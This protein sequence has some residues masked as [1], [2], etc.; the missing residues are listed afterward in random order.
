MAVH[1]LLCVCINKTKIYTSVSNDVTVTAHILPC[2]LYVA[3]D[4]PIHPP[5]GS[6]ESNVYETTTL[7][8]KHGDCGGDIDNVPLS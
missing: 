8:N 2:V 6:T 3:M 1:L 4:T 7:K 5:G